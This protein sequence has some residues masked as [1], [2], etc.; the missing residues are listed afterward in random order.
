MLITSFLGGPF[1]FALV[2]RYSY[3]PDWVEEVEQVDCIRLQ[4]S[5]PWELRMW[6]ATLKF[7]KVG[8]V[9]VDIINIYFYHYFLA[10][11]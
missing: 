8:I 1:V 9:V 6:V 4:A 11:L 2:K 5:S 10:F 7:A 3:V